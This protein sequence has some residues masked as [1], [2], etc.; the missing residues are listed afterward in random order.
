MN[1]EKPS[2]GFYLKRICTNED[3]LI[4]LYLFLDT[5]KG[6]SGI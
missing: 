6:D 3:L 2:V 1:S 5:V 4:E